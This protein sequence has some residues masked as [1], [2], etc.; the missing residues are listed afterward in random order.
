MKQYRYLLHA[1]G[2]ATLGDEQGKAI[3][4]L[5]KALQECNR[6]ILLDGNLAD[7]Y[8]DFIAKVSGR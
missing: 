8:V 5:S 2:G 4:I 7:I 1:T 6:V 3:A